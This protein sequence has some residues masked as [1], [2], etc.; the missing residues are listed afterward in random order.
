MACATVEA[1]TT[2]DMSFVDP[3]PEKDGLTRMRDITAGLEGL[4]PAVVAPRGSVTASSSD[5]AERVGMEKPVPRLP[6]LASPQPRSPPQSHLLSSTL[7]HDLASTP[8]SS[9]TNLGID[10]PPDAQFGSV[11]KRSRRSS[12]AVRQSPSP[13]PSRTMHSDTRRYSSESTS[14]QSASFDP[15]RPHSSPRQSRELPHGSQVDRQPGLSPMYQSEFALAR[16]SARD[17]AVPPA[18]ASPRQ[19]QHIYQD[20]SPLVVVPKQPDVKTP[21]PSASNRSSDP[22]YQPPASM[23]NAN[24]P[25]VYQARPRSSPQPQPSRQQQAQAQAGPLQLTRDDAV[26]PAQTFP[27]Q[28]QHMYQDVPPPLFVVPKQSNQPM[29]QP[30]RSSDPRYQPPASM[31]NTNQADSY[32]ARPRSSPQPQPSRQPAQVPVGP[33]RES[34]P[35][36]GSRQSKGVSPSAITQAGKPQLQ[37]VSGSS[38]SPSDPTQVTSDIPSVAHLPSERPPVRG[39]LKHPAATAPR[40]PAAAAGIDTDPWGVRVAAASSS[41]PQPKIKA[42]FNLWRGAEGFK[43]DELAGPARAP[44]APPPEAQSRPP[45]P[46]KENPR[47]AMQSLRF[48]EGVKIIPRPAVDSDP[49]EDED[50]DELPPSPR[51]GSVLWLQDPEEHVEES[52]EDLISGYGST[53]QTAAQ[54]IPTPRPAN[55]SESSIS[56]SSSYSTRPSTETETEMASP[57]SLLATPPSSAISDSSLI[58]YYTAMRKDD[59]APIVALATSSHP[60]QES[61]QMSYGSVQS[62]HELVQS[63]FPSPAQ[64]NISERDLLFGP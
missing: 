33:T 15:K 21:Q 51:R 20:V 56:S 29:P 50:G 64:S 13:N 16:P 39:I 9:S 1:S 26:L 58:S 28:A 57:S 32:Q 36:V 8:P 14:H 30:N 55:R 34:Y 42:M 44:Q 43:Q 6:P 25:D 31:S 22:R 54:P 46:K 27:R 3:V 52:D 24:H 23:S 10:P 12:P 41:R 7:M 47:A 19:G 5:P 59:R 38:S 62:D 60:H 45:S 48:A 18:Q 37:V 17:D 40:R 61:R 35:D 49:Y 2:G 53:H 4:I 11:E 63:I